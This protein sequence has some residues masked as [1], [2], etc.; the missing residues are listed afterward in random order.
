MTDEKL[1]KLRWQCRRGMLELD[2]LLGKFLERHY[3]SLPPEKQQLFEE[4]LAINDQTLFMWFT[5]KEEPDSK[6]IF[7]IAL[8]KNYK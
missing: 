3:P 5:D 1:K 7:I 8:C 6:F 4:F 2:V